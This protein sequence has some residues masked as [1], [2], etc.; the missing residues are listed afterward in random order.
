M[1]GT[2]VLVSKYYNGQNT[3]IAPEI[4][5]KPFLY[6]KRQASYPPPFPNGWFA[7]ANSDEIQPGTAHQVCALGQTFVVYRGDVSHEIGVLNA[8]CTH[9]GANLAQGKVVNDEIVCPFHEWQ[10]NAAGKCTKIPYAK[11]DKYPEVA[12]TTSY[13][14][15]EYYGFVLVYFDAEKRAPTYEPP[16]YL[17]IDSHDMVFR[18][19]METSLDM[20]LLEF[21]ENSADNQHFSILHGQMMFP[22]TKVP[23]PCIT[24]DH[25]V[26]FHPVDET[27]V[28]FKD[29][30]F[31]RFMGIPIP[32][33]GAKASISISGPA[34]VAAFKF[35]TEIG[36]IIMFEMHT[37][38]EPLKLNVRF[39]WYADKSI[40]RFLV[41]YVIGNW[42][43]QI[44]SDRSVWENK[45][46]LKTPVLIKEDGPIKVLRRWFNHFYSEN[47]ANVGK[48]SLDW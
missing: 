38:V 14:V 25:T 44:E 34:G 45:V 10:F 21:C 32:R 23:V 5:R 9:M 48:D 47:S 13:P 24:I 3:R 29:S 30:A 19:E 33:S 6:K 46:H 8:Y 15:M 37:P 17:E 18:G 11:S 20:H 22:Y 4:I 31:L 2:A 40:P 41:W 16:K 27:S 12:N 1:I 36:N 39:R 43:S 28:S 7:L 26:N 35:M 42:I